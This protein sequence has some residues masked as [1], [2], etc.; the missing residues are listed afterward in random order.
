MLAQAVVEI[1]P[2][3]VVFAVLLFELLVELEAIEELATEEI[4]LAADELDFEL[5]L[6][7]T[8]ELVF[9]L[10]LV[11]TDELDFTL[12][13]ET[14]ELVLTLED[15]MPVPVVGIEH[16]FALLL[17]IGSEPKVATLQ[18]KVPFNTL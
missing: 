15:D 11:A 17:G 4:E 12:E 2:R 6:V 13:L 16:S 10:E 14:E 1:M 8:E 5:E 9:A 3:S 18:V 7:A